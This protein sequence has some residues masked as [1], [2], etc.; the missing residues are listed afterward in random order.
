MR[1]RFE[2]LLRSL[3]RNKEK[4]LGREACGVV[5]VQKVGELKKVCQ[6]LLSEYH[7]V[8][9]LHLEWHAT[10]TNLPVNE[11]FAAFVFKGVPLFL[12]VHAQLLHFLLEEPGEL[13]ELRRNHKVDDLTLVE[14]AR[15]LEGQRFGLAFRGWQGLFLAKHS[16][17]LL[18]VDDVLYDLVVDVLN[19]EFLELEVNASLKQDLFFFVKIFKELLNLVQTALEFLS[20]CSDR[21]LGHT[22]LFSVL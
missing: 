16:Q 10:F 1:L 11:Q 14:L 20:R 3:L 22:F 17:V 19:V 21:H 15:N 5:S 7:H 4:V 13:I 8:V 9:R 12:E 18:H 2:V 6:E